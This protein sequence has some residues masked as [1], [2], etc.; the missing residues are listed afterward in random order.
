MQ[1][2]RKWMEVVVVSIWP[3]TAEM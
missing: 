1:L 2:H 3:F